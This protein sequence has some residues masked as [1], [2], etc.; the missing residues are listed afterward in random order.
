MIISS[1]NPKII[2]GIIDY[3]LKSDIKFSLITTHKNRNKFKFIS[4]LNQVFYSPN[5]ETLSNL[6]SKSI[7]YL[8]INYR[9]LDY[10]YLKQ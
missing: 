5:D 3:S 10:L 8:S 6:Y 2:N 9:D 7:Y 1:T 4:S